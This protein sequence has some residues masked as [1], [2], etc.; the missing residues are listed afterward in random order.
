M[1]V[2]VAI[3]GSGFGGLCAA[4]SL[5]ARGESSFVVIEKEPRAGGVWRDN[6]YPGCACDVPA[7]LYWYSLDL[8]SIEE[9]PDWSHVYPARA[10]IMASIDRLIARRGLAAHLLLGTEALELTW[11]GDAWRIRTSRGDDVV[12]RSV[13][14]ASGQLGRPRLPDI[15]GHRSFAG[16]AFHSARWDVRVDLTGKRVACIGS[17]ASAV[18]IAPAIAP[19][20]ARL[21]IFQRTPSHILPR[22]D[23]AYSAAER[24]A[25]RDPAIRRA[26]RASCHE[27]MESLLRAFVTDGIGTDANAALD[28]CRQHLESQI[29]DPALRAKLWPSHVFGCKRVLVSDDFYPTLTRPN[30]CLVTERIE[31]IDTA[32][33]WTADGRYHPVDVIVYATGFETQSFVGPLRVVGREQSLDQAWRD[34]PRTHLGMMVPGFPNLFLLYGPNTGLAH[35]SILSVLEA[36]VGYVMECQQLLA[37]RGARAVEPTEEATAA[38]VGECRRRMAGMAWSDPSCASWYKNPAGEVTSNWVGTVDEYV[39]RLRLDPAQ[40][41]FEPNARV[42]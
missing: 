29:A 15:R 39:D 3:V 35:N 23:R 13:I 33:L 5:Q 14:V 7:L 31:A 21:S 28:T 26:A 27:V 4:L 38:F 18:Q 2:Q 24:E 20:V 12:A 22:M 11:T 8:V 10:E 9:Q 41:V 1:F 17:A 36:Q 25:F 19:E 30:V 34:Y 16:A 40:L 32:G 37:E 42:A 6:V